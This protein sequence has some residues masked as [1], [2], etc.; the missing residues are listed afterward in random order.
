MLRNVWYFVVKR[1]G[2]LWLALKNHSIV[3]KWVGEP[4]EWI[5]IHYENHYFPDLWPEDVKRLYP[6][7]VRRD[8]HFYPLGKPVN[9][10][11]RAIEKAAQELGI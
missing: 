7:L 5:H 3:A 10:G 8:L 9:Q 11:R 1:Q 6:N 2:V 4:K